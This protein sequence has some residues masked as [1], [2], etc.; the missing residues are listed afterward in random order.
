MLQQI[1]EKP[2]QLV[3]TIKGIYLIHVF[4]KSSGDV[5]FRRSLSRPWAPFLIGSI[6][7]L[8]CT[9]FVLLELTS[10]LASCLCTLLSWRM[11]VPEGQR[12][13][14]S[15]SLKYL[16]LPRIVPGM[17]WT[18]CKSLPLSALSLRVTPSGLTWITCSSGLVSVARVMDC[19]WLA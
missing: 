2:T 16:P 11:W 3:G 10:S 13:Y 4:E 8:L 7:C 1:I 14:L 17:Q 19:H 15:C 12:P 5:G 18:F 6:S 9:G